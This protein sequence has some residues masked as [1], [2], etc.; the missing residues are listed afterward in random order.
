MVSFTQEELEKIIELCSQH[1]SEDERVTHFV[2]TGTYK[3]WTT[4]IASQLFSSVHSIEINLNLHKEA[5][6]YLKDCANVT[7][8]HGDSLTTLQHIANT[9]KDKHVLWFLDAHQSGPDTSNNGIHVPLMRELETIMCNSHEPK[10]IIIDD[11]RLFS[12]AWDWV[13]ITFKSIDDI[14]MKSSPNSKIVFKYCANDRYM[15]VV[16]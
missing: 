4:R 14:I 5:A 12:N 15:L 13:G 2:E 1:L 16:K 8:Y 11:V 3:G 7:L 6:D 10:V 9:L